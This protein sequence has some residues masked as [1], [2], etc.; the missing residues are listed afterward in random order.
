MRAKCPFLAVFIL[1]A[2]AVL[3]AGQDAPVQDAPKPPESLFVR[4]TVYPTMSLSRYDYNND[5][6]LFEIRVYAELRRG[7]QEG[8]PVA[9]ARVAAFSEKL[10]YHE[11]H[12]EKRI[13]LGKDKLPPDVDIEIAAP[14]HRVIREKFP[15]PAWLVLTDPKPAIVEAGRDLAVRWRFS[16]FPSP[17]DV[18]AYDFRTGK[19]FFRKNHL[20]EISAVIPAASLPASTI[21]RIYAIQSWLY[22]R[23]LDGK[24]YARGSEVNVIPWSQVFFR[25]KGPAQGNTP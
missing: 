7:S 14:G 4:L 9:D 12:Y 8:A 15:L 20:E 11:D 2:T 24:D 25:T 1:L 13:I 5:V 16:R 10:E 22:K 19:E 23:Y 3:P 21:V 17:V 6:D 18:R